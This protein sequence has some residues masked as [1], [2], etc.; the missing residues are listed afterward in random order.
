MSKKKPCGLDYCPQEEIIGIYASCTACAWGKYDTK[1]NKKR[2]NNRVAGEKVSEI[3]D[4][5]NEKR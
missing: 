2:M 4:S 3:I 5:M 1:D